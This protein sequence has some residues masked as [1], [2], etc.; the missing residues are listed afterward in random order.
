[1]KNVL[2]TCVFVLLAACG[3]SNKSGPECTLLG[4]A[5]TDSNACCSS[6]CDPTAG[7]CSRVPGTCGAADESCQTGPDCCSLSCI[8]GE[9]SGDQ[10]TSE[11]ASC[12]EDGECCGGLC[13]DGKCAP[14]NPTCK[15]AGNTCSANGECCGGYCKDGLCNVAVSFCTQIGDVCTADNEC[16][17]GLCQIPNGGSL[18]TC[19]MITSP[20]GTGCA[21]AG[22]LCG[23]GASYDGGPL[24]ICG[25][26]CCSRACYPYGPTGA[27]ICQP[28]SGCRPTGELCA[29]DSDCCGGPGTPDHD[30]SNAMCRKDPGM[31]IG[32]C[33]NGNS[34][35]PAGAICRLQSDSCNANANCCAG[36]VLQFDTCHKDSLGIPRCGDDDGGMEC[37]FTPGM[38]CASSADCCGNP[39]VPTPGEEFGFTCASNCVPSSGGCTTDADCCSGLPCILEPGSSSGVCGSTP[40]SCVLY[41]QSCDATNMCCNDVPCT[42]GFC[43]NILQ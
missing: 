38:V 19:Q 16:C 8:D 20:G 7:I 41:G 12:D 21:G 14:L 17:G 40:G 11:G 43:V 24:P 28:P 23:M 30:V 9:C 39:C 27:T 42:N 25:G 32:R 36:N 5:C 29:N 4:E 34:C 3:G 26:E 22:S 13:T 31:N 33:D 15:S 10:C 18:G 2:L 35:S 1:M 6:N 37:T